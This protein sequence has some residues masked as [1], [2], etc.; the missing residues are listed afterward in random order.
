MT[1]QE[2][3]QKV[4]NFLIEDFE[5]EPELIRQDALLKADL[6]ID[7]LD[8]VD[9]VVIVER[10]FGFKPQAVELKQAGVPRVSAS[11]LG[12]D[13][14]RLLRLYRAESVSGK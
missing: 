6:G 7:S 11:E 13:T 8:F 4:T 2:I 10:E 5:I 3:E 9:I 1:R 14:R 12:Q